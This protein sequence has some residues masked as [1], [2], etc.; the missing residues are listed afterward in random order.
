[1][2][3]SPPLTLLRRAGGRKRGEPYVS[4]ACLAVLAAASAGLGTRRG[5][6]VRERTPSC[7]ARMSRLAAADSRHS[8]SICRKGRVRLRPGATPLA[9]PRR[10]RVVGKR[11]HPPELDRPTAGIGRHCD[12]RHPAEKRQRTEAATARTEATTTNIDKRLAAPLGEEYV[13]VSVDPV[14]GGRD[15]KPRPAGTPRPS[16]PRRAEA[17]VQQPPP[18]S[19]GLRG[20]RRAPGGGTII[21]AQRASWR[22]VTSRLATR[23]RRGEENVF[24]FM[25]RLRVT[26]RGE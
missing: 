20:S 3:C 14:E 16:P 12:R 15:V 21:A 6:W 5:S 18:V 24:C 2:R 19:P 9:Q 7:T 1:V 17:Q 11:G 10:P 22:C 26:T 25:S 4:A 8:R 13:Q 23:P